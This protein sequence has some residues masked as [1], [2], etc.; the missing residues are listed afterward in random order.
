[1]LLLFIF[2]SAA[3]VLVGSEV[4]G[5]VSEVICHNASTLYMNDVVVI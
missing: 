4:M 5:D 1:M 2:F 3:A